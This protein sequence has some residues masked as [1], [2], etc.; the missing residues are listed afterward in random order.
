LKAD[1]ENLKNELHQANT[2]LRFAQPSEKWV[3]W[4]H[5]NEIKAA[6]ELTSAG[7]QICEVEAWSRGSLNNISTL[8]F[9]SEAFGKSFMMGNSYYS[10]G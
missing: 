7:C 10:T 4:P 9:C 5:P 2:L 8:Q 1:N 3:S 6:S